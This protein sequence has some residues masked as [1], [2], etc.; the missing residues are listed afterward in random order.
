MFNGSLLSIVEEA[1]ESVLILAEGVEDEALLGSRLTRQEIQ[2]Q[3]ATMARSLDS[4][5]P[6]ARVSLP[7]LDWAAWLAMGREIITAGPRQDEA[8]LYA[9]Q[10]LVPTTLMWL[11]VYKQNQPELFRLPG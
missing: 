4:L 10:S 11:R 6:D 2:R 9:V 8:L 1:A 5:G 7:E 3:L